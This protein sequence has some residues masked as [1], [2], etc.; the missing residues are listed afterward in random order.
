MNEP[1]DRPDGAAVAEYTRIISLAVHEMRTPASVLGGYLK[2]LIAEP[3]ELND[4]QRHMLEEADKSCARLVSLLAELS[5]LGKLDAGTAILSVES[6]DL[7]HLIREVT[8]DFQP[9]PDSDVNI[10][11]SGPATGAKVSGDRTRLRTAFASILRAVVREQPVGTTVVV[12]VARSEAGG[13]SSARVVVAPK[14]DIHSAVGAPQGVFN[15]RRAGLGLGLLIARRIIGRHGG[16]IWS[17]APP[18]DRELPLGSRGAIIV[19]LPL[20]R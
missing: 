4:R 3:A 7:F 5:D 19:T 1:S 13:R 8:A 10:E 16:E 2:M 6:I 9:P 15:D 18:E 14:P 12:D 11:S 20:E 17:P